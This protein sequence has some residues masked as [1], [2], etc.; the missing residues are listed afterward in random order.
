V[1]FDILCVLWNAIKDRVPDAVDA[2]T[3]PNKDMAVIL[4]SSKLFIY[5]IKNGELGKKP[6][7]K[8]KL[9]QGDSVIMAEWGM[10][11]YV[12]KWEEAFMRNDFKRVITE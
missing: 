12:D 3:S 10:G 7:A 2:Y 6:L 1:S 9:A 11:W 5:S 4:S 8:L